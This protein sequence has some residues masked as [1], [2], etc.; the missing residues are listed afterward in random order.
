MR[1]IN[2]VVTLLLVVSCLSLGSLT[3]FEQSKGSQNLKMSVDFCHFPL[4]EYLKESYT[5]FTLVYLF[6]INEAGKP[7]Q[8]KRILGKEISELKDEQV[9]E[10]LSKWQFDGLARD[11]RIIVDFRWEHGIGWTEAGV[12]WKGFS[13]RI[14]LS[15]SRCQYSA[16]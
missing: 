15:G 1:L 8:I 9:S 2:R 6:L 7:T 10:C 16:K 5:N 12:S 4:P 3:A 14:K 13:Q 11:T